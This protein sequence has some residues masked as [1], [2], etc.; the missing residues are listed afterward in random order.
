MKEHSSKTANKTDNI[1]SL[2]YLAEKATANKYWDE[3]VERWNRVI[4]ECE[5][6]GVEIPQKAITHLEAARLAKAKSLKESNRLEDAL[7]V[8]SDILNSNHR[9]FNALV[10]SAEIHQIK[11]DWKQ[12]TS[13]YSKILQIER[14]RVSKALRGMSVV[15]K[16]SG[17]PD[18]ADSLSKGAALVD[19][20]TP[21]MS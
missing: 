20:Q 8:L 17:K 11:Q 7:N 1:Q 21:T 10:E 3:A 6:A 18:Q 16:E 2:I 9:Q 12:A 4:A 14:R 13:L 5:S 15:F 19:W